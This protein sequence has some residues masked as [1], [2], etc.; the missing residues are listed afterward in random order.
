ARGGAV[1]RPRVSIARARYGALPPAGVGRALRVDGDEDPVAAELLRA[2]AALG[3]PVLLGAE[4]RRRG[5]TIA[6][7]EADVVELL[8]RSGLDA[9]FVGARLYSRSE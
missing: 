8:G 1:V 4:L 3:H 7:Q 9:A 6:R 2:A 5:G